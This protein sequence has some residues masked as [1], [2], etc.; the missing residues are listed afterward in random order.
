[1]KYYTTFFALILFSGS[2]FFFSGFDN[3][4]TNFD[5]SIGGEYKIQKSVCI[6]D[7]E[8][9]EIQEQIRISIA[10]LK[11]EGKLPQADPRSTVT[12]AWPLQAAPSLN[13]DY[14][15]YGISN[16]IDHNPAYP[17]QL[18]DYNCGTRT[19]DT[20][21]GYNHQGTDI[22]LWPF[23][24][25]KMDNS[26]VQII[27]GAP[28][29][30]VYKSDG[31]FDRNCAMNNGTWNAVY[32]QHG[33]GSIAWYGH[34]KKNSLTPKAVGQMV[35]LGEYL[36]TVGSSG[37]STGPHLHF[38]VYNSS[39]QLQDPWQGTC[40]NFTPN[41]LWTSQKP[42]YDP[43]INKLMTHSAPPVFPN[44]PDQEILNEKN[45]F[46]SGDQIITAAYYRDQQAG[47][48]SEF[49][50]IQPDNSVYQSWTHNSPQS[51]NASYW[52]WIRS[53]PANAQTG[54]WK[55]RVVFNSQTYDHTFTVGI[56][57]IE[58]ISSEIPGKFSL[59]QNYPNPFNPST[60]IK[61]DIPA[62]SQ[63]VN[64]TL[65]IY[66][67]MGRE[68]AVLVNE[69]IKPGKYS[70]NWDASKISSGVYFY[71]IISGEFAETKRMLMV[72]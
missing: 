16:F 64:T 24:W 65:K 28:G 30:I 40:N 67:I 26:Q 59:Y 48:L 22:F 36:G 13:D 55:F 60:Q 50:I 66:D 27:A 39:N 9:K 32:I 58:P 71:R 41:S 14:D 35:V 10:K 54:T 11:S 19:Y 51:Y 21:T 18:L 52:Y 4:R 47:Q 7:E 46:Q 68:V 38:E 23:S 15:Y 62:R 8:R 5:D 70:V 63:N 56:N 57:A 49:S 43:K 42:Y 6:T 53:L 69:E 25:Y 72:K 2:I 17:N 45:N 44:C 37:S 33:D 1:M 20:Q 12:F 29:T 31:N 34:M 61:F 3:S